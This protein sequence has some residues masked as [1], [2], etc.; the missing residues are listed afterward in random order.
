MRRLGI[1]LPGL[2]LLA[3]ACT[4]TDLHGREV[5]VRELPYTWAGHQLSLTVGVPR[6]DASLQF[7]VVLFV[8][9]DGPVCE[10]YRA[11]VWRKFVTVLAGDFVLARPRAL[12]NE[13]CEME[14]LASL[15]YLHGVEELAS[16]AQALRRAFPGRRLYLVAQ[17]TGAYL[18]VR[19]ATLPGSD[20]A[21][22][23]NLGGGFRSMA[24]VIPALDRL[25]LERGWLTR[26]KVEERLQAFRQLQVDVGLQ[27]Q[28]GG[29]FQGR[30]HR[31]WN[32]L[33]FADVPSAWKAWRGPLLVV[34]GSDDFDG[35]P[36]A[37]VREDLESMKAAGREVR[38]VMLEGEGSN[39]LV[40][41]AFR[42]VDAWLRR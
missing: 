2:L 41:D 25:R 15:D 11:K 32:Q 33:L 23:V 40:P 35:V 16:Q 20:V 38:T 7:P 27:A 17:G 10:R 14:D 37:L 12:V 13:L 34:H 8:G 18:A 9:S 24:E 4:R 39:L 19:W 28:S 30:S 1:A 5:E 36:A 6:S 3:L 42:A 26:A 31:Y 21:G 22:V 29:A